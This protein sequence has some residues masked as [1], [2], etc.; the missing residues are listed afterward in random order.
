M[1]TFLVAKEHVRVHNEAY[2]KGK[3]SFEMGI[4]HIADLVSQSIKVQFKQNSF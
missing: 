2:T 3:T 1:L 4:N